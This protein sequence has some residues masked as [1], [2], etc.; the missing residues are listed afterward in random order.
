VRFAEYRSAT[1]AAQ[2]TAIRR[3]EGEA[4]DLAGARARWPALHRS[5]N[6]LAATGIERSVTR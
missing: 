2:I 3:L 6:G 4:T 5:H 1:A